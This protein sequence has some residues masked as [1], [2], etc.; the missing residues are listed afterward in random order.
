MALPEEQFSKAETNGRWEGWLES[1]I[2]LR[3]VAPHTTD[4]ENT[5]LIILL[6]LGS[7]LC[8]Q[9]ELLEIERPRVVPSCFQ[10]LRCL[11][12]FAT[13]ECQKQAPDKATFLKDEDYQRPSGSVVPFL[14]PE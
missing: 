11:N 1:K 2:I 9:A 8:L 3:L 5:T 4:L 6:C 7:S 14:A 12:K 13:K 10:I